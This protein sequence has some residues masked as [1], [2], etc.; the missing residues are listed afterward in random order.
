MWAQPR[1][2][3]QVAKEKH[4]AAGHHILLVVP[5]GVVVPLGKNHRPQ[6]LRHLLAGIVASAMH[7]V[8]IQRLDGIQHCQRIGIGL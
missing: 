8:V 2:L 7:L 1:R 4:L 3:L 5:M 6:C